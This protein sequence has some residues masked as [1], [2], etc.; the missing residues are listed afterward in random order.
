MKKMILTVLISLFAVNGYTDIKNFKAQEIYIGYYLSD[1]YASVIEYDVRYDKNSKR[2]KEDV[3]S[4]IK[5]ITNAKYANNKYAYTYFKAA[6]E[7]ISN[8][9]KYVKINLDLISNQAATVE[10]IGDLFSKTLKRNVT[11][12]IENDSLNLYFDG[13]GIQIRSNNTKAVYKKESTILLSWPTRLSKMELVVGLENNNNTKTIL[14]YVNGEKTSPAKTLEEI[15]FIK[16][17]SPELEKT[18]RMFQDDCDIVRLKDLMY[19][20]KLIEKYKLKTG[21]YP[22]AKKNEE[23]YCLIYNKNQKKY[24]K[25]ENP[26][27]HLSVPPEDFFI[28]LE[29][30]LG[31]KIEQRFDP[32]YVPSGRPIFYIYMVNGNDYYFAVHLSKYYS[33]SKKIDSN[34]YKVEISNNDDEK[35]KIYTVQT[36]EKNKKYMEAIAAEMYKKDFFDERIKKHI[37]EYK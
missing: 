17:T 1:N 4:L 13:E 7:S 36:L 22:F 14:D 5:D 30:E 10:A 8:E 3:E 31:V 29:K 6:E 26:N 21:K 15:D 12:K 18:E 19:Y 34:Y 28:E 9:G 16:D 35:Y 11:V 2:I 37:N 23:V 25:D 27:K 32:Q 24:S 33:F 20:G